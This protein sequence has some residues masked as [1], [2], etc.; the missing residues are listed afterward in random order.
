MNLCRYCDNLTCPR[1]GSEVQ[2]IM[3]KRSERGVE[4]RKACP[5]CNDR[6]VH[7]HVWPKSPQVEKI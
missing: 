3:G 4:V 5:A 1:C 7:Y 6:R 2:I